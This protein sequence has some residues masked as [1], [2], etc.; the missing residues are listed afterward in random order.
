MVRRSSCFGDLSRTHRASDNPQIA[1]NERN[2]SQH[3]ER[4]GITALSVF[5][6]VAGVLMAIFPAK[7]LALFEGVWPVGR[8]V[9]PSVAPKVMLFVRLSDIF[10]AFLATMSLMH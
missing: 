8:S 2:I 1:S 3:P 4:P 5:V 9:K 10:F 7:T 6:I